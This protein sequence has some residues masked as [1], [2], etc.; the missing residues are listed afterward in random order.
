MYIFFLQ[1]LFRPPL[2]MY[3]LIIHLTWK[4]LPRQH[5]AVDWEGGHLPLN[6][7]KSV[8]STS[9]PANTLQHFPVYDYDPASLYLNELKVK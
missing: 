9:D 5:E 2:E 4:Q 1:Q 8:P 7:K 3:D 6:R